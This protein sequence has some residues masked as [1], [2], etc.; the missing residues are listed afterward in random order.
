VAKVEPKPPPLPKL[1]LHRDPSPES[2]AEVR[3]LCMTEQDAYYEAW[4]ECCLVCGSSGDPNRFI[5]CMD[6]GEVS[7]PPQP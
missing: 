4:M 1:E 5:F 3:E 2:S 6:C 7:E